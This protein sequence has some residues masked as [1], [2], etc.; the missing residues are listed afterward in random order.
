MPASP[1]ATNQTHPVRIGFIGIG[2]MGRI[3]T[4]HLLDGGCELSVFDID[5]ESASGTLSSG[6]C[7]A[8]SPR[9]V[10]ARSEIVF[11]SLPMPRD[12]EAVATGPGGILEGAASG[13]IICDVGTTDP[14]TIRRIAA[15]AEPAG[16]HVLDSPVS[17][18]TIGARSAS[19]CIMVGGEETA[20]ARARPVLELLGKTILHCGPLGSGAVCKIA[21]NLV[22]LGSYFLVAEAFA[23]GIKAGVRT[24]TLFDAI[25]NSSGNTQS[26]QEFP[27]GLFAGNFEGFA[28]DLAAKDV[29]LATQLG[30][31][32]GVPMDSAARI[33]SGSTPRRWEG[34]GASRR[35][36]RW[37]ASW[38]NGR[39][40]RSGCDLFP[41]ICRSH[42][43][44]CNLSADPRPS[45]KSQESGLKPGLRSRRE[46]DS[47]GPAGGGNDAIRLRTSTPGSG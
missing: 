30:R 23:L 45:Q 46:T 29:G 12:V 22:N 25:S 24:Q 28:L 18:G 21:N 8:G 33:S 5:R 39:T 15:A 14:D 1:R 27:G 2:N 19:L 35:R 10:A 17:G 4:R 47:W 7:W 16:V 20:F 31:R 36:S 41:V 42:R 32:L 44:S 38:R 11:T 9:D 40:S 34:A 26:M 37:C 6:A 3:M 13:T 43:K